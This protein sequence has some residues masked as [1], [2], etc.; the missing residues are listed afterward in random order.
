M[1]NIIIVATVLFSISVYS[2]PIKDSDAIKI[3]IG[4][5]AGEPYL[6]KVGVANVL[7]HRNSIKGFYGINNPCIKN[8]PDWVW[9]DARKAWKESLTNDVTGGAMY[10]ESI[11][12]KTPYWAKNLTKTALIKNHQFYK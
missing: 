5:S 2:E 4:E 6:G 9:R 7:R 11:K 1:K 8:Q 12:F 10:F 3:I